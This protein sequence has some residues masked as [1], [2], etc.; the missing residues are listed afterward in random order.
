MPVSAQELQGLPLREF[1]KLYTSL[2]ANEVPTPVGLYQGTFIGPAWLRA[3]A[4]TALILSGLGGWWGKR[5]NPDGTAVNLV[6]RAGIL[7]PRFPMRLRVVASALDGQPALGLIYAPDNPFPWPH[8][9][10]ELRL[11][12][13]DAILGM[14]HL[15]TGAL[16]KLAF[17]FVLTVQEGADGL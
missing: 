11:L 10:D 17:P 13:G 8:I 14:T 7:E 16:K 9:T 3:V 12:G 2:A 4:P 5:F 6:K 1:S 15:K